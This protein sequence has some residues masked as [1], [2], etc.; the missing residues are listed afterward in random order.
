MDFYCQSQTESSS[1]TP[2]LKG[3]E[4]IDFQFIA[5]NKDSK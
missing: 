2:V 4:G 5:S 3:V 1:F